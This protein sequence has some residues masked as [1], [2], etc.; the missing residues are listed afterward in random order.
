MKQTI[1]IT[2]AGSGIGA[3]TAKE[4]SE[5]S[6]HHL[7][8]LGRNLDKLQS[9]KSELNHPEQHIACSVD[10]AKKHQIIKFVAE[11]ESRLKDLYA[12]IACAGVGGENNFG[13]EDRWEEIIAT[14]LTGTY[15]LVSCLKSYLKENAHAYTHVTIISSILAHL[16][17]P[18]YTAYC[19]SKSGLLGLARSWA[20]ELS[21]N[22]VLVNTICPGWVNTEM[23][24]LGIQQMA[25]RFNEDF[26]EVKKGQMN[27]VPLK[28]MAEPEEVAH[29]ISYIISKQQKSFTGEV[30]NLNNGAMM[31]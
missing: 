19:A 26:A 6:D 1:V 29:L 23:A 18:Q 27:M 16:G 22:Q 25:E 20:N 8:L 7:L 21:E 30:F 13:E 24:N 11:Q 4:L 15:H 17:V 12:I 9:I 14:N 28:K 2:G 10:I 5:N 31:L 3:A